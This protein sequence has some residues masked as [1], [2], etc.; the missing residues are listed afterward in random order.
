MFAFEPVVATAG[1][2]ARTRTLNDLQQLT[3]VPL[4]LG[5]SSVV[6]QHL[7]P[8]GRGMADYTLL[9]SPLTETIFSVSLDSLWPSISGS[10]DSIDGI[11]I[12]VQGMELDVLRGMLEILRASSPKLVVELH[13]GVDRD[14]LREILA[15]AGYTGVPEPIEEG[16]EARSAL[17]DD[18]SYVFTTEVLVCA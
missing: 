6:S 9:D 4:A 18:M 12:D 16:D 14:E 15:S 3:I 5:A 1:C 8:A 17:L 7:V 2:L 10:A 13:R 11:K